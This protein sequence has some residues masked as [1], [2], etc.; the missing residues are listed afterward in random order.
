MRIQQEEMEKALN[1]IRNELHMRNDSFEEKVEN[2]V[3]KLS[4]DLASDVKTLE[5]RMNEFMRMVE[6]EKYL[7]KTRNYDSSTQV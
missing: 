6:Q 1:E 2:F 7:E 5:S 3:Q 4:E